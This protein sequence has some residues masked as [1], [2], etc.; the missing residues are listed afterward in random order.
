MSDQ[1]SWE[2]TQGKHKPGWCPSRALG[3]CAE[4]LAEV[5]TDSFNLSLL[6][7]EVPTYFKKTTIIPVPKKAHTMCLNDYH[8]V[9]LT[10]IIMKCFERLIMAHINSSLPTCFIPYSLPTDVT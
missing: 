3:S 1:S 10:S 8:P 6:Q 2:S 7:A 4:Q 5:F 9:A